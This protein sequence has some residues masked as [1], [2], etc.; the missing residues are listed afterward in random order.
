ML[1]C[2]IISLSP[3]VVCYICMS[4]LVC[5]TLYKGTIPPYIVL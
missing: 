4:D 1:L 3:C 2:F 5:T